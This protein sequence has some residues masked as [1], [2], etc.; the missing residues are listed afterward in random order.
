MK[1]G[2]IGI[3]GGLGGCMLNVLSSNGF[4]VD[5]TSRRANSTGRLFDLNSSVGADLSDLD[6]VVLL[7]GVHD[8]ADCELDPRTSLVNVYRVSQLVEQL[9]LMGKKI[10]YFSSNSIFGGEI[11]YASPDMA[12]MPK[13]AYSRQ[14]YE[15]ERILIGLAQSYGCQANLVINRISKIVD[16]KTSP[17]EAWCSAL[18][19]GFPVTAF[20]DLIFSPVSKSYICEAV[21]RQLKCWK[22]GIYHWSGETDLNYYSFLIKLRK[23]FRSKSKISATTSSKAGVEIRFL[24]KYSGMQSGWAGFDGQDYSPL[25]ACPVGMVIEDLVNGR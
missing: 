7:A 18:E 20:S 25:D 16:R 17:F 23:A 5:G 22:G 1:V 13:I 15:C 19:N 14:K 24:P 11:A 10:I 6:V 3:D 21:V 2:V 4:D 9:F 8:Y 12:G